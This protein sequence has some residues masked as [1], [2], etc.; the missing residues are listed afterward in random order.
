[1]DEQP[2]STKVRQ[3]QLVEE[4][5]INRSIQN[6]HAGAFRQEAGIGGRRTSSLIIAAPGHFKAGQFH[7]GPSM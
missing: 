4:V 2:G 1:M 7:I 6:I 5:A 3:D